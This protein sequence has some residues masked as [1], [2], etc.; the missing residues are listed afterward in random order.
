ML[1]C[2]FYLCLC[3]AKSVRTREQF[4]HIESYLISPVCSEVSKEEKNQ[5]LC[6]KW[7]APFVQRTNRLF[8]NIHDWTNYSTKDILI[9][10]FYALDA[11]TSRYIL[12]LFCFTLSAPCL[13]SELFRFSNGKW[14]VCNSF[15]CSRLLNVL[16]HSRLGGLSFRSIC[17]HKVTQEMRRLSTNSHGR[18][19]KPTLHTG[20]EQTPTTWDT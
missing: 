8:E 18:K 15:I 13:F 2:V 20:A 6:M 10:T 17:G 9:L 12:D 11:S 7:S 19:N 1:D 5:F 4:K 14:T 16:L 3:A